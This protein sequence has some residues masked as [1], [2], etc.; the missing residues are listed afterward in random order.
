MQILEDE[1][2]F[3][4]TLAENLDELHAAYRIVE[5]VQQKL[6]NADILEAVDA[7]VA[8]KQN[9]DSIC[10]WPKHGVSSL[11]KKELGI[12]RQETV[13]RLFASWD[14]LIE[15]DSRT[16]KLTI[17]S[18]SQRQSDPT[19]SSQFP[20]SI[21]RIATALS[22]L[23]LLDECVSLFALNV[24]DAIFL[25]CLQ[26]HADLHARPLLCEDDSLE[27]SEHS[28]DASLDKLFADL[29][30]AINYLRSHLP[31]SIVTPL[32]SIVVPI[33]L[34]PL[35]STWLLRT[36]S[37]NVDDLQGLASNQS[38]LRSFGSFLSS[39]GWPGKNQLD[40]WSREFP[41][42]WVQKRQ[43][44]CLK[45][46]RKLLV[47]G[48]GT[49]RTVER[50][51]TQTVVDVE[52]AFADQASD[53]D[54]NAAWSDDEDTYKAEDESVVQNHKAE[55]NSR[56]DED[57][58]TAWG[59]GED[60]LDGEISSSAAQSSV[61][62]QDAGAWG[63]RDDDEDKD[64]PRV[65]STPQPVSARQNPN[66][67]SGAL[68]PDAQLM[69]LKERYNITALPDGILAIVS[70]IFSDIGVIH[71]NKSATLNSFCA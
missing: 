26:F 9:V 40:M 15:V 64:Q 34:P 8:A 11:L 28:S 1:I 55:G 31:T 71:T 68:E 45:D 70:R 65:P 42:N 22:S 25:P 51:E 69:T 53:Q 46:V 29:S 12:A 27:F 30:L 48:F 60:S 10:Y 35:K 38:L 20:L 41:S 23:G 44:S 17:N 49:V 3:S 66:R 54:W 24:T 4:Q 16:S 32:A 61:T 62:D 36:S 63:W 2:S 5:S 19:Q 58:I 33:L 43:E 13:K 59:L 37:G 21:S 57:E 56:T 39:N 52:N 18:A 67:N 50:T 47:R 6:R 7:L 14:S